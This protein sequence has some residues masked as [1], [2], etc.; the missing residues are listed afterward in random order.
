MAG[1][2]VRY[3][4]NIWILEH[5][6]P[7]RTEVERVLKLIRSTNAGNTVVDFVAGHRMALLILPFK[8]SAEDRVN[9]YAYAKEWADSL[10]E[11]HI[12][13]NEIT[14]PGG[15]VIRVPKVIGTGKGSITYIEFH[16]ATFREVIKRQGGYIAPGDGPGEVLLHEM[17]HAYRKQAG[18]AR[19]DPVD[20]NPKM[21]NVEEFYSILSQNVYRSERG[22]KS[23]RADHHGHT[24]LDRGLSDSEWYYDEYKTDIDAW[25]VEQRS[26]CLSMAK[27][28]AKFNPFR[29]AAI[30]MGLMKEPPV[31]MAL[32][33]RSR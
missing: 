11:G 20:I 33:G 16:P 25:F 32:P 4:K 18:L 27:S 3:H 19:R 24:H 21:D 5:S 6:K 7:Y 29:H 2:V 22:F 12:I 23:L 31:P 1:E 10:K 9:A 14:L 13:W 17:V 26:F 28:P 30:Q 8:P 15:I